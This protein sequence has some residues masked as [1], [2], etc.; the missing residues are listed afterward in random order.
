MSRIK[1]VRIQRKRTKGFDLQA[2]SP[3]GLPV[4]YVGRPTQYGNPFP[5][6]AQVSPSESLKMFELHLKVKLVEDRDF[7]APLRGYNVA[8]WCPLTRRCHADILLEYLNGEKS[9]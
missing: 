8:C 3:N 4:R 7:L 5:F 1:P 9:L 2:A 6:T